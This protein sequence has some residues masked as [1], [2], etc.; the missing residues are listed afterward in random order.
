MPI[1][2]TVFPIVAVA[3]AGY[4][5][6]WRG[7]LSDAENAALE[8]ATFF[9]LIPCLLFLGTATA[10]F[11]E[12]MDWGLLLGFYGAV[13]LVYIAG[14]LCARWL[15][16]YEA[17][18][19]SVFGMGCAYSNVTVLGIPIILEILGQ[20]ALL[21]MFIIIAVHNMALFAFGIAM[22]ERRREDGVSLLRH[23]AGVLRGLILNPI[24]GSLLAGALVNLLGV[25]L[26]QPALDAV[27]LLSRAAPPMALFVVGCS[28]TRYRIR[29][30]VAPALCMVVAK[31]LL[32]PALVWYLV[33]GVF[34]LAPLWGATAVLLATMPVGISVYVFSKRYE[35]CE[36]QAAAAIVLSS[37]LS[38]L[39]ISFFAWLLQRQLPGLTG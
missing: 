25:P 19:Q 20:A 7:Y 16:G 29:G 27:E 1:F 34:E 31:L 9:Y 17:V 13:L 38:V 28:L 11:P 8:K 21:P 14:I 35:S 22:A 2:E 6:R 37:V 23:I 36:S 39:S 33:F 15:F 30:E 26:W 5:I 24:T 10:E 3:A 4:F 18:A 32:L 12:T